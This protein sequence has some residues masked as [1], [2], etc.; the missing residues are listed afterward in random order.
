M[1]TLCQG[2]CM[3]TCLVDSLIAALSQT[4]SR[5]HLLTVCGFVV[6]GPRTRIFAK[7][8]RPLV[9]FTRAY[10]IATYSFTSTL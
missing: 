7:V 8:F 10:L 4:Q 9:Q 5:T 2:L 1:V 3:P 6:T